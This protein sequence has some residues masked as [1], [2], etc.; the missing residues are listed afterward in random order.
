MPEEYIREDEVRELRQRRRVIEY[1]LRRLQELIRQTEDLI[2]ESAKL[3]ACK[4]DAACG[5]IGETERR[6]D[7]D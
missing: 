4:P 7:L 6:G 3:Q 1:Q 2:E 5:S